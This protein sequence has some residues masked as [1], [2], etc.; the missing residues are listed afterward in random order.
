[1]S[2]KTWALLCGLPLLGG[3][4][5][6][7]TSQAPLATTYPATT[8]QRM[9]AAHH[10]EV[11]ARHEAKAIIAD[12]QLR[13]RALYIQPP[14]TET[15]FAQGFRS[16]LT[17]ELVR[18]GAVVRTTADAAIAVTFDVQV[19]T[20]RDRQP[21]RPPQGALTTLAA[22]IAVATVPFNHWSEPALGLIPAA[23]LVDLFSG[24][25][26]SESNREVIITVQADE[27]QTL[28]YSSSNLYYI[29]PGDS[30]Q[31]GQDDRRGRLGVSSQ[32]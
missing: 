11:L 14:E 24:S 30:D 26:T 5:G 27:Y 19:V 9:Q 8:Q 23:G 17:S 18:Q 29:N 22:G 25:W 32:W 7:N 2:L 13:Q 20:H 16:L 4:F 31:Y 10:W 6:I 3:C 1:M 21:I 12:R 15:A 28:L